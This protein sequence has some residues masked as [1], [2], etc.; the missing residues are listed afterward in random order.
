VD[1]VFGSVVLYVPTDWNVELKSSS[2][3]GAFDDKRDLS[4]CIEGDSP[5]LIIKG[6]AAF[7][8]GEIKN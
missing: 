7:G 1:V 3:L 2:V 6:N 5:R 8:N 4:A